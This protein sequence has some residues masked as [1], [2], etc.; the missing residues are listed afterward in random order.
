M[1]F[2]ELLKNRIWLKTGLKVSGLL[3]LA[4]VLFLGIFFMTVRAGFFGKIPSHSEL[5]E[6][7]NYTA[8]EIYSSDGVLLGK[9]Y[10]QD[11]SNVRFEDLAPALIQALVATEDARFYKHSGIDY[12]S[13]FRVLVKSLMMQDES[14]GGGSTI[15]Q[16]LAKNLF[17]RENHRYLSMP[18]NKIREMI[19]ASR[20]EDIYSKEEIVTLY[21]NTVPFGENAYGIGSA[22]KRFFNKKPAELNTEEAAV[23][24]GML[25]AT[26][27]YNPKR[28]P[29][30]SKE[31]RNT[32]LGQMV[33]Y[34]YLEKDQAGA[35]K[36]LPL[37]INYV[38]FTHNDGLA[39]YFREFLRKEVQKELNGLKKPDGSSYNL[40]TD[41][42]K[43][44]TSIDSR[45]QR[46]AEEAVNEHMS[47]L[48]M[49]F[50]KHWGKNTPWGKDFDVIAKA[51]KRSPRYQQLKE[52][53]KTDKEI[54]EIFKSPVHMKI[55]TWKGEEEKEMSP[56]DSIKYYQHFLH[57]SFMAMDPATGQIKA[58]VGGLNHR[59]FQYDHVNPN[60][61][62]QVGSTFK[63]IV[64]A[65]ALEKGLNPCEYIA[66][67]R[68]MFKAY[69]DWSPRNS[70]GKYGGYYSMEG[71]LNKSVNTI[72]A[73]VIART[74]IGA[75]IDL[76][77]NM[78]IESELKHVPSISLGSADI[79]L[80][81]MVGAYGTFANKGEYNKP[82]Y[83]LKITDKH[84]NILIDYSS[85]NPEAHR[86]M[87][88]DN[89]AILTHM[90]KG[91]VNKG[92]AVR[93]RYQYNLT[94]EIA[95]KTGTTQSHADGWFMGYTPSL[96]AGVW[97]GAEDRRVHFRTIELGQGANMALPI[98]GKF[99]Q[100]VNSD[101]NFK[102][103]SRAKFPELSEE[104]KEI[105]DCES[106]LERLP[107]EDR[108]WN[109]FQTKNK[110]SEPNK[111]RTPTRYHAQSPKPRQE[112]EKKGAGDKI[113][114]L[115]R[116]K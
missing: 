72:T 35:L 81:E 21:L 86:V 46:Y 113:R 73:N 47:Q 63:P 97:V 77:K 94:N 103:M 8:S 2:T 98:W 13:M 19:I 83:L 74:G 69:E 3:L 30:R 101:D 22:S 114:N 24:I 49:V 57:A 59:H 29:E 32:V 28:Y 11:R 105:I 60:S 48:Q 85:R 88:E 6:I 62:R 96:V 17:P 108:W 111:S 33:K 107:A 31:R 106:Y 89:A 75:V 51:V 26:T 52:A 20:M 12:K 40:Y 93:L 55:F 84:E 110:S 66:N 44:H 25:K 9:Y 61:K 64:Y 50:F 76:A 41:G 79:S 115:F 36:D 116:K 53:G 71:G 18:I 38:T 4:L 99:I 45:L 58:W 7:D 37:S 68:I 70:D 43:I 27:L 10:I 87:S 92:T 112:E 95:G 78:G 39:T 14:S 67:R 100:K 5:K 1:G 54:Q 56:L 80:F 91:V 23:L 82:Q 65:A 34:N 42:L 109:I 104:V 16:Q 15:S 90:L 102:A